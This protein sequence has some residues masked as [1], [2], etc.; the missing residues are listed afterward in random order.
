MLQSIS[1][2]SGDTIL[3]LGTGCGVIALECAHQGAHVICTDINPFAV[4]LVQKNYRLNQH[5][6]K[7]SV[8]I[9]E[10]DLF[11]ILSDDE[12]F[13]LIIFNPPYLPTSSK[14]K[15]GKWFDKA[16]DGGKNGLQTTTRYI[17]EA[18][19]HL[20]TKGRIYFTFS[21]LSNRSKL[22]KILSQESYTF[23]I[24][25]SQKFPFESVD[26]YEITPTD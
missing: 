11:S 26:I 7:G 5:L 22:E 20:K 14:E 25:A 15:I 17:R 2:S 23:N 19:N 21:S 18:K 4:R 1:V 6:L 3:E 8:E 16:V 10:G 12:R 24:V 9:R 13:H